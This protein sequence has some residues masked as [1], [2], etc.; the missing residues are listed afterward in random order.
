[1]STDRIEKSVFLR[2]PRSRVWQALS[3]KDAFGEWF[4]VKL[5]GQMKPG[6]RLRGKVTHPGYEDAPFEITIDRMEPERLLSWRWHPNAVDP[7]KDYSGEPS[8]LVVFELED[9][10]GGTRLSVVESGFDGIPLPRRTEA[11]RGN[12]NGWSIQV[13]NIERYVSGKA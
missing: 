6:A 7:K 13:Q 2:A 3:D 8:T 12:E 1:M 5:D 9:A 10:P 4:G 11:Y